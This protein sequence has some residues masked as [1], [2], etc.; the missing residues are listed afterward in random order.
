[1]TVTNCLIP[2][3]GSRASQRH[4]QPRLHTGSHSGLPA[5]FLQSDFEVGRLAMKGQ[6][7]SLEGRASQSSD[8]NLNR[9]PAWIRDCCMESIAFMVLVSEMEV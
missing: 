6:Q 3:R 1:M 9:H 4:L 5:S 7:G 8:S 2:S